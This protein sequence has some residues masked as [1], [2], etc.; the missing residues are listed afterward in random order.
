MMAGYVRDILSADFPMMIV[1]DQ[2]CHAKP[3]IV[4]YL[5]RIGIRRFPYQEFSASQCI[6][7]PRS[8]PRNGNAVQPRL[9]SATGFRAD[10]L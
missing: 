4:S 2:E 3:T 6:Q 10:F 9:L 7:G 5:Y 8:W 1:A